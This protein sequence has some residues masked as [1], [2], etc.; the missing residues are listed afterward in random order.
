[1]QA[2][3][4]EAKVAMAKEV[5]ESGWTTKVSRGGSCNSCCLEARR[6]D[7]ARRRQLA[8]ATDASLRQSLS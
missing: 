4:P 3:K 7:D 6:L 2:A 8:D 5:I 1:M